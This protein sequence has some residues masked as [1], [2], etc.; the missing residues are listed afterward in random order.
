MVNWVELH[1]TLTKNVHGAMC[2]PDIVLQSDKSVV[3]YVSIIMETP[4]VVAADTKRDLKTPCVAPSMAVAD[5]K[6]DVGPCVETPK[7]PK[8]TIVMTNTTSSCSV[9]KATSKKAIDPIVLGIEHQDPLYPS[10]PRLTKHQMEITEAQRIESMMKDIYSKESGRSRGW[11]KVGLEQM[12]KPRC[13][14]GGDIKELEHARVSFPWKLIR[15]DKL[16]SAF[17]D[18]I[19]VCKQI[20]VAVWDNESK[21]VVL[22]P[23]ADPVSLSK[24]ETYPLYHINCAGELMHGSHDLIKLCDT[25]KFVLMPPLSVMK[26]LS[27]LTIDELG[28]IAK[29]LSMPDDIKGT[30][31]E[32]IA[33]IASYKVRSRV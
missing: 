10:A 31:T 3:D 33:A 7:V 30:K 22:Y 26:S 29:Q 17:L 23:A 28:T 32:R 16:A 18:F 8:N 25:N 21:I 11:T 27:G 15:D 20:R 2:V 19:C 6:R 13:A 24:P 5:A 4:C 14:S 1:A 9:P 12:L